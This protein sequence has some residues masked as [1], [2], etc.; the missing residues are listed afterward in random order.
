MLHVCLMNHLWMEGKKGKTT[1]IWNRA[2]GRDGHVF[3]C[4]SHGSLWL[5]IIPVDVSPH[6]TSCEMIDVASPLANN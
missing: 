3:G 2:K 1:H 6:N 5:S 4:A